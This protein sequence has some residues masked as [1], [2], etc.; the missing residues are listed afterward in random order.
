M[1]SLININKN[2]ERCSL[3]LFVLVIVALSLTACDLKAPNQ[4]QVTFSGPMMGTEYRVTI[5]R[6]STPDDALL[7]NEALETV[8]LS[9]MNSVNQSMSNYIDD[10]ELSQFNRL[11]ANQWQKISPDFSRV[12]SEAIDISTISGG[13]FDVTLAKAIDAW[14][15]GPDGIITQ[16]PSASDLEL[17][18]ATVG[19]DKLSYQD[20]SLMKKVDGVEVSLSAI[21]KGYAVDKVA[22]ALDD[23]GIV[24]YLIN[25][26]GEL[27]AS[28]K[29]SNDQSWRVGIE[30]PHILGG[31]QEIAEL[32]NVAIA[33]SG[34][35]RNYLVV[36]G[37][38]FS[39]TIDP[40]TLMPVYHK[41]ALVSVIDLRA[42][43]ADALATAMMAMDEKRAWQFAQD[44]DLAAYLIIRG[45]AEGK[46]TVQK[47][48]K[49]EAYL[50]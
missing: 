41:L 29:S 17:L 21:A 39:H 5:I 38:Q 13:A 37:Q 48:K 16:R 26:G 8:I 2:S 14:G 27:R 6:P 15:F 3:F 19:V 43:T 7:E 47:T 1:Q 30:K 10:S 23:L 45:D 34:D 20:D 32:N 12:I 25:I 40:S 50:Q 22:L 42:S 11:P 9:A 4:Q 28:G 49:F 36:D 31:I 44:N 35:Y 18:R 24:N 46:Y 33:T